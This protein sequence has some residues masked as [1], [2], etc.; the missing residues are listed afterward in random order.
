M[1][2]EQFTWLLNLD[3]RHSSLEVVTARSL[4]VS[5]GLFLMSNG[6]WYRF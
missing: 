6:Q 3:F 2:A 1:E 4:P 5:E